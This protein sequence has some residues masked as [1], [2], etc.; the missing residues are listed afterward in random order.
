M[1]GKTHH[2]FQATEITN[3]ISDPDSPEVLAH[4]QRRDTI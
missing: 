1:T 2:D 4:V 3:L